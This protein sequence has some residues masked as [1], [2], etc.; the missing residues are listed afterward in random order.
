MR[1]VIIRGKSHTVVQAL[2][3]NL[4]HTASHAGQIILPA[5]HF[6]GHRWQSLSIPRR[7]VKKA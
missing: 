2:A 7:T 4:T 5:K 6:A 1:T 3:R